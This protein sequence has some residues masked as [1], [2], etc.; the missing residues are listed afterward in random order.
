MPP[1]AT[2]YMEGGGDPSTVL[3]T[4]DRS[5]RRST[6]KPQHGE[7][8][9]HRNILEELRTSIMDASVD[10]YPT[11]THMSLRKQLMELSYDVE[12]YIDMAQHFGGC[13]YTGSILATMM[14]QRQRRPLTDQYITELRSRLQDAKKMSE[15][16]NQPA[17]LKGSMSEDASLETIDQPR[18]HGEPQRHLHFSSEVEDDDHLE[19]TVGKQSKPE[20]LKG[21][22]KKL[23]SMVAFDK[24]QQLKVVPI[25]GP[26]RVGKTTL[27]RTLYHYYGGRFHHRAFIRMSPYPDTRRLLTSLLSQI[28]GR[29]PERF[30]VHKLI[31]KIKQH[32]YGKSYV[33]SLL[34][35]SIYIPRSACM[36]YAHIP[37]PRIFLFFFLNFVVRLSAPT[38]ISCA[39]MVS[40]P[41]FVLFFLILLLSSVPTKTKIIATLSTSNKLQLDW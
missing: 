30:D 36:C 11:L 16:S 17:R 38:K 37:I 5:L 27:A 14:K 29:Q 23:A 15:S 22:V 7:V 24:E 35:L 28:K 12:D 6:Q 8:D 41:P 40:G 10:V 21:A 20:D 3:E 1:P 4:L 13:W 33:Y 9:R 34:A 18:Q 32:L 25:F 2:S 39:R 19:K 26:S 31:D